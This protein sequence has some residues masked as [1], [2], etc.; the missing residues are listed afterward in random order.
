MDV[1]DA[2]RG[3]GSAKVEHV[4]AH[5]AEGVGLDRRRGRG[6]V[7]QSADGAGR[8]HGEERPAR[9][10]LR[11]L[12]ATLLGVGREHDA[13]AVGEDRDLGVGSR[14]A[15]RALGEPRRRVPRDGDHRVRSLEVRR[16]GEQGQLAIAAADVGA[17]VALRRTR[18]AV[19]Q[20]CDLEAL[21]VRRRRER[22]H[23]P[24]DAREAKPG[25]DRGAGAIEALREHVG[26][27]ERRVEAR[28]EEQ[29]PLAGGYE[30]RRVTMTVGEPRL[31]F[32][33]GLRR[34]RL[35][36]GRPADVRARGGRR[37]SAAAKEDE[38]R[39]DGRCGTAGHGT[40]LADG[41]RSPRARRNR[42]RR[43][44]DESI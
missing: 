18:A 2:A 25:T 39:R 6:V 40:P 1:R 24:F 13:R 21:A 15:A 30:R 33:R 19:R 43:H 38:D 35:A 22:E 14:P 42:A 20:P 44:V 11:A 23:V 17:V 26:A 41:A 28:V 3:V 5:H 4:V 7:V 29:S 36:R 9:T 10:G 37:R 34:G 12:R 27:D 31:V 32:S 8:R 16:H